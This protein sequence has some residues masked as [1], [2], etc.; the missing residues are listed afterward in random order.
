MA[1]FVAPSEQAMSRSSDISASEKD[2]KL[3]ERKGGLTKAGREWFEV[4][5]DPFH[6]RAIE[7]EGY[8]DGDQTSTLVQVIKK[9]ITISKPSSVTTGTWDCHVTMLPQLFG[10]ITTGGAGTVGTGEDRGA[11]FVL[12]EGTGG[13]TGSSTGA[14]TI[15]SVPTGT[16]PLSATWSYGTTQIPANDGMGGAVQS[17]IGISP[18]SFDPTSSPGT[19]S[20]YLDGASRLISAGFEVVNTTSPLNQQGSCLVYRQNAPVDRQFKWN[21]QDSGGQGNILLLPGGSTAWAGVPVGDTFMS[22][23]G[24]PAYVQDAM[25]LPDARQWHAKEGCYVV[26]RQQGDEN[27]FD[28]PESIQCVALGGD[29]VMPGYSRA[30]FASPGVPYTAL[31]PPPYRSWV[32]NGSATPAAAGAVNPSLA[33]K[34]V[35]FD[36]S[37][38]FFTGLSLETTLTVNCRWIVERAPTRSESDLIVIAKPSPEYDETAFRLYTEARRRMPPGVM[39][40]DNWRGSWFSDIVSTVKD[41]VLPAL[42]Q[43]DPRVGALMSAVSAIKEGVKKRGKKGGR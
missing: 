38:A 37:G 16:G 22:F 24:P 36:V 23:R 2:L 11:S 10:S 34:Y 14:V 8:P 31:G 27:P 41:D 1:A 12:G 18:T 43:K 30:S 29:F 40:K 15:I 5:T 21:T 13:L 3:L 6:D 33:K 39:L 42:A 26:A 17:M 4:A 32:D 28:Y 20:A 7:C 19:D 25:L 9:T 35:P